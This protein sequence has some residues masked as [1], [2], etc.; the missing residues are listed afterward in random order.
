MI[1]VQTTKDRCERFRK[2]KIIESL[3]EEVQDFRESEALNI[4][5][6]V[7][8]QV[9]KLEGETITTSQIRELVNAQLIKRGE[10]KAARQYERVGIPTADIKK[11]IR[12]GNR[13]N[14]NLAHNPETV[15][16]HVADE[17]MKQYALNCLPEGLSEAHDAGLIHIHDL[18]YFAPR[19]MNCCAGS[20]KVLIKRGNSYTY[21]TFE[22]LFSQPTDY[23]VYT[24]NHDTQR[25]EFKPVNVIIQNPPEPLYKVN[26]SSG[27]S[28]IVNNSHE[29]YKYINGNNSKSKISK[30]TIKVSDCNENQ[31]IGLVKCSEELVG[32]PSPFDKLVGFFLGDGSIV[33]YKRGSNSGQV[34]FTIKK[35]DKIEFLHNILNESSITYRT[36]QVNEYNI[37]TITNKEVNDW[38]K[39]IWMNKKKLPDGYLTNDTIPGILAGLISSDGYLTINNTSKAPFLEY[40]TTNVNIKEIFEICCFVCGLPLTTRVQK[41]TGNQ[42]DIYNQIP[43]IY[44]KISLL[45]KMHLRKKQIEILENFEDKSVLVYSK[46]RIKSVE[47]VGEDY[48][49]T[50]NVKD[51]HNYL[52]GDGLVLNK[53]CLQHDLRFF[54]RNGLK[55]DGTG[56]H[57]SVAGPANNIE[58]LVNHAGQVLMASQVNMSGGQ[59]LPLLNVFMAPYI[60]GLPY[61][62]VKQAMQMFIFNLNMSYTS[63]GGQAVFSS[64]NLEFSVPDFLKD[65]VAYGPGGELVGVYGDYE[66]EVRIVQRA[67]TEVL[68]EGD[69]MGKPHFFPNTVYVVRD[70]TFKDPTLH[71]DILKVHEVCAKY[72]TPYFLN[73]M[74]TY[75]GPHSDVM[76]CRTRLNTTWTG[77]WDK[78]TLR[79]G[80]LAYITINLP[81]IAHLSD[82]WEEFYERLDKALA[83]AE[84]I[85][86]IRREHAVN[87]LNEFGL[88]RFLSQEDVNGEP[89]YRIDNTTLS[90]GFVGLNETLMMMGYEDGLLS[91]EGKGKEILK[92]FNDYAKDLAEETGY[93]WT[94]IATPAEST[95]HRFATIDR[96]LYGDSI[97]CN[98]EEGCYYYTNSSHVPV[99]CDILLPDRMRLESPYHAQTTGG[100]IFHAWLG[101]AHPNPEVLMLMTQRICENSDIG[102]F[103]YSG[104]FSFCFDCEHLMQGVEYNCLEC[105]C[106][107]GVEIF[108]RITGYTQ[109]IGNKNKAQGGWNAG[110]RAEF[111][112]RKRYDV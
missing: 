36:N 63:R 18:D 38:F 39:T 25:G 83:I 111:R 44:S 2:K 62:R 41:R 90:F 15:H 52:A 99:D 54:I 84:T 104:A 30:N 82:D 50:F 33:D 61:E 10:I 31:A 48:V 109:A 86:L 97:I 1:T 110:K 51:N 74:T 57:T 7:E 29:F 9:K 75:N 23:E 77:D 65:E 46:H 43:N 42:K 72:S 13:D 16:K 58:T 55:V 112:D 88:M 14:A 19:P 47:Y 59:S 87:C 105:G 6:A 53:N 100:N 21:E 64:I 85:L 107:D 76:G 35:K 27:K 67:I 5:R 69:A 80:N 96:E 60:R 106:G 95:A 3:L 89:Y 49:Y 34:R 68:L 94:I 92:H 37:T 101:E 81:R 24:Y 73:Q 70:N 66:E 102:F 22:N 4:A 40:K 103:A 78:D 20:V 11:L 28:I 79:T 71:D 45:K 17:A 93:R 91:D 8:R 32:E 98:G 108:D 12:S 56:E 26:F